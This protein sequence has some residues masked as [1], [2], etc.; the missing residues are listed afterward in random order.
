MHSFYFIKFYRLV[1]DKKTQVFCKYR[2]LYIG[3]RNEL[4]TFCIP[5]I[6]LAYIAFSLLFTVIMRLQTG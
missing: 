3:L 1:L 2:D 6:T 4:A 5:V